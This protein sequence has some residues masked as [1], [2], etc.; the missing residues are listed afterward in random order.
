MVKP[1]FVSSDLWRNRK[2]LCQSLSVE[3]SK[4]STDYLAGQLDA[5]LSTLEICCLNKVDR[6]TLNTIKWILED[7][8]YD[9]HYFD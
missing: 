8:L 7:I 6:E 4:R 1:L 5:I 9:R 2:R 3:Y